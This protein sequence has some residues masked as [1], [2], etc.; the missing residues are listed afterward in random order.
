MKGFVA[1]CLAMVPEIH[2]AN[3][4][5]PI[6]LAFSYDEEVGCVGVRPLLRELAVC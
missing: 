2:R 6:H 3:L 4:T 1:V 5:M